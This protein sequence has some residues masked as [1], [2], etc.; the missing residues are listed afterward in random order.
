MK[1]LLQYYLPQ[2]L[3][4]GM[5]RLE[6]HPHIADIQHLDSACSGRETASY[7][8]VSRYLGQPVEGEL[9]LSEL[10]ALQDTDPQSETCGN[11]HWYREEPRIQDTNAAFFILKYL[12]LALLLCPD[13]IPAA[14][15][16][17]IETML[18][19][20][21]PWFR[22][23]CRNYG[24]YYPNKIAS[25][26]AMLMLI[27]AVLQRPEPE[28]EAVDFWNKWLDYTA[29]YGWGW[30][31][32]T[33]KVYSD[34]LN[35]ALE[36][37]LLCMDPTLPLY[38]RV[39]ETRRGM[40]NYV[41]YHGAYEMTPSIRTYNFQGLAVSGGCK[42]SDFDLDQLADET[43]KLTSDALGSAILHLAAPKFTPAPSEET[44]HRERIFLDS[45][46]A[47]WKGSSIRLGTV[48]RYPVMC[49]CDQER[50]ERIGGWGLGWQSMPV[51]AVALRHET[52]FLRFTTTAGGEFRSHMATGWRDKTLFADE[53]IPDFLTRSA[54]QDNCAVVIRMVEHL[55]NVTACFTDEWFFQHFDGEIRRH[56]DWYLFDY[57]DC[58]LCLRSLSGSL[59]LQREGSTLRLMQ[60]I[61]EGEEKLVV[62]RRLISAWAVVALDACGC[63]EA[64]LDAAAA[65]MTSVQDLRYA[66]S[67][68]CLRAVCGGAVLDFDPD[69]T[70]LIV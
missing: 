46:A 8:F 12:G 2:C 58:C 4:R 67:T 52:S 15:R 37:A 30:G 25:D 26:G 48:S 69:K 27:A 1:E 43:G 62:A 51:S 31:E 9:L 19:R 33:S 68:P 23:E 64:R 22:N 54:Q 70:D 28:T 60:K 61:Y 63:P 65:A 59:E 47:T 18:D 16:A 5:I 35:D 34:I 44:F 7:Y 6:G 14:E 38:D 66:R 3:D 29:E 57:G 13:R 41:A 50:S 53:N 55:A 24:Y 32:N 49:G 36:L 42:F 45:H 56:G 21:Q 20:A 40:L 10:A 11:F 17:Y 39:L